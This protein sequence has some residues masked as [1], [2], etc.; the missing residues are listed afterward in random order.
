MKITIIGSTAYQIKIQNHANGLRGSG[1]EVYIPAFNSKPYLDEL[2]I[3]THNREL[4]EKSD[5][6]HVIWDCRSNGTIFDL[7]MCF[8]LRKPI[9]IIYLSTKSVLGFA[10]QYAD[11]FEPEAKWNL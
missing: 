4:I 1:H 8:A 7:G 10:K 3:F 9:K 11:T 5:E 6:V 2:G